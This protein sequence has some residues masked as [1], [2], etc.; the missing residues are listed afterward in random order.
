MPMPKDGIQK[1]MSEAWD[2]YVKAL[3]KSLVMIERDIEEAKEMAGVCTNEWCNA[4][5][6]VLYELCNALFSIREPRWSSKEETNRIKALKRRLYDIHV[7]FRGV[8]KNAA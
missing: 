3:E 7:N 6:N 8:Y 2:I 5:E 1:E 4:T